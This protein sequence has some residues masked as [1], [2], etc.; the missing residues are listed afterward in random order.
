MKMIFLYFNLMKILFATLIYIAC[1]IFANY[2]ATDFYHF[3]FF[4]MVSVGTLIFGITFTQRDRIHANG[5]SYVYIV[6]IFTAILNSLFSIYWKIDSRI[7]VA[8]FTSIVIAEITDTEI[9]H[10]LLHE[11]WIYR[12][13]KS[14][15]VSVPIDSFMFNSIAFFG[16]L[17]N[18]DILSLIIGEII[19]KYF[20][21]ILSALN[22]SFF[23]K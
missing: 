5:K 17:T 8:S 18:M 4:G 1:V 15:A 9:Y 16:I 11:K 22:I 20:I 21:S 3:P 19:I 2:T 7:I 23:K 6:I 12:V 10:K 14:N 13:T